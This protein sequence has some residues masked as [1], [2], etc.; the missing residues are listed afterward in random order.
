MTDTLLSVGEVA[1]IFGVTTKTIYRWLKQETFVAPIR[2][3][4]RM[5]FSE[6]TIQDFIAQGGNRES[7]DVSSERQSN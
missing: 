2:V 7:I 5:R 4:E 1:R 3:G 6:K